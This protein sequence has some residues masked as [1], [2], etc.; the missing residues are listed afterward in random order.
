VFLPAALLLAPQMTGGQA[1]PPASE[2]AILA[3]AK[4]CVG[5]TVD[6]AGQDARLAGWP[7][8]IGNDADKAPDHASRRLATRDGVQLV[9]KTGIDGGCVVDA[10]SDSAFDK[11]RFF[12][13][14]SAQTGVPVDGT[15]DHVDLPNGELMIVRVG[16]GYV[17]LVVANP[18]GKHSKH[19]KGN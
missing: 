6:P 12:A 13:D 5:A 7:A 17:Q 1:L 14:L 18:N 3:G 19:P 11:T 10:R 15:K 9:V 2:A 4:A 8:N 16:G